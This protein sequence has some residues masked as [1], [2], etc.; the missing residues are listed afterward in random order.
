MLSVPD[1]QHRLNEL[2]ATLMPQQPCDGDAAEGVKVED[3]MLLVEALLKNA[4]ADDEQVEPYVSE[5]VLFNP[6]R[7]QVFVFSSEVLM[8]CCLSCKK[9]RIPTRYTLASMVSHFQK[10]FDVPSI[11]GVYPQMNEV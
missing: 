7:I 10:L 1:L 2:C 3:M 5:M 11:I 9:L 6:C 8:K 4:S